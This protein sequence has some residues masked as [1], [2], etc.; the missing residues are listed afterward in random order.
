MVVMSS[1]TYTI[2]DPEL[3]IGDVRRDR[4]LD[5]FLGVSAFRRHASDIVVDSSADLCKG[6]TAIA[7]GAENG[8]KRFLHGFRDS[9]IF[10]CAQLGPDRVGIDAERKASAMSSIIINVQDRAGERS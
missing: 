8:V 6:H 4:S 3:R 5:C 10:S 2:V 7:S 9:R 1:F